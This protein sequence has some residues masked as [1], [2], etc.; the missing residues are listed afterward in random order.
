V[1]QQKAL[2]PEHAATA[3]TL[4]NLGATYFA[5][6][7][8]QK[9]EPMYRLSLTVLERSSG[10]TQP[11]LA[12]LLADYARLLRKL[13]RKDEARRFDSRV[14]ELEAGSNRTNVAVDW[15]DLQKAAKNVP[16]VPR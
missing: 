2:R 9:A 13:H 3:R 5:E 1:I 4:H 16:H 12:I 7:R 14:R 8:Y 6:G 10:P 11:E 15:R